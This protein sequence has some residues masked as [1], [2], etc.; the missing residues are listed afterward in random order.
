MSL[1]S[2]PL[3]LRDAAPYIREHRDRTF[4]IVFSGE[5]LLSAKLV[6]LCE[7]IALLHS[8]GIRIVLVAGSRPQIEAR[9]SSRGQTT[10]VHHGVRV[11]DEAAL[12]AAKEAAG[13]NRIEL[14]RL[15][16]M[17]LPG[18]TRA[19]SRIRVVSGNFV[20]AKPFGVQDGVDYR[21]TGKVRRIAADSIRSLLDGD[22]LVLLTPVGYS[23]TGEAFNLS[24][25][26]LAAE[27]ATAIGA[28]KL[29][30]LVEETLDV[31]SNL[32]LSELRNSVFERA[33]D[34]SLEG[35]LYFHAAET[36]VSAG[37]PRTH[38]IER[39]A[40]GGLLRELFTRK[41]IGTLVTRGS[42][43]AVRPAT[44]NEVPALLALLEPL[45]QAGLLVHRPREVLERDIDEFFVVEKDEEIIGCAALR[46][47]PEDAM[48]ELAC[49]AVRGDARGGGRGDALLS[50]IEARGKE[51]GL[52]TL[53]ALTTQS[54]HWFVERGFVATEAGALPDAR[55]PYN[56]SRGSKVVEKKL[57]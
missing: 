38:L 35:A 12:V 8:I 40:D 2:F 19:G 29:I 28:D 7:D 11:T 33:S 32:T 22:A 51:L 16:T 56:A 18:S 6:E 20:T 55:G 26:E 53:F 9:L 4:V 10:T 36:A 41:G 13:E 31:P 21:F 48:G 3:W 39:K 23:I 30:C 27:V 37:V 17:A 46:A 49:L 43:D 1:E 57:Y 25:P 50:A 14:E 42:T 24:T 15:L 45:E 47:F 52:N 54:A 34:L 44:L 5:A